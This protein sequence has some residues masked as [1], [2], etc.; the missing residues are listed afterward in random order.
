[1]MKCPYRQYVEGMTGGQIESEV[2][3]AWHEGYNAGF[4]DGQMAEV[5]KIKEEHET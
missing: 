4:V 1:M 3:R 2:W 5:K